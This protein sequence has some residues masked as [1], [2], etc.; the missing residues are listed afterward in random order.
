MGHAFYIGMLYLLRF[1]WKQTERLGGGQL[2]LPSILGARVLRRVQQRGLTI[3]THRLV[4]VTI[5]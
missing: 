3:L 5:Y 1:E 2:R 4:D